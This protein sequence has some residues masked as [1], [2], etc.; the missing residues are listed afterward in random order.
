VDDLPRAE[1]LL[2]ETVQAPEGVDRATVQ[3]TYQILLWACAL[4]R[5]WDAA[6]AALRQSIPFGGPVR[7]DFCVSMMEEALDRAGKQAQFIT[8]CQEARAL[9][10]RAGLPLPLD[11]WC[12]Q[13]AIRSDEFSQLMFQD[14]FD[15][16]ELRPVWQWH[17]PIQANAFSLSER[18]GFLT[19][20]AGP[21]VDLFP[22]SNLN[23]PRMLIEVRGDFALETKMAGDWDERVEMG[24]SGLLLWKDVL[25]YVCLDKF[26]MNAR[27]HGSIKLGARIRGE[28]R[29]VGRGL[30]RG[31]VFHLGWSGRETVSRRCA[32]VTAFAGRAVARWSS[33][34]RTRCS[35]ACGP[36]RAW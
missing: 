36:R 2:C 3:W 28:Y 29:N 32:A 33:R 13:P 18:P 11:P 12:L 10:T 21:E 15:A 30:L 7:L 26:S 22:A 1:A 17:D 4:Q 20:R 14:D 35:R 25:N 27:Y 31:H 8:F 24:T 34:S 16:R 23:A 9:Y 6:A 19:I 5:K